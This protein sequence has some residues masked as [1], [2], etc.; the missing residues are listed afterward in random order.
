MIY[1][2]LTNPADKAVAHD[3]TPRLAL[4]LGG[5]GARAAYQ[6]G[7]LRAIANRYPALRIPL[8]TGVSAGAINISYL[9]NHTGSFRAQIDSLTELWQRLRLENVFAT[10]GASLLWRAIRIGIRLSLGLPPKMRGVHGMVDTQPLRVFLHDTLQPE[11]GC[12]PGIRENIERGRLEAVA[13]TAL[14]YGTGDT[15]TFHQGRPMPSWDQLRRRSVETP[16]TVEHVMA[17]AALPLFFPPVQIDDDWYGDGGIRLVN[18][19][20][21]AMHLGADR[22]LAISNHYGGASRRTSP[23]NE[24]PSPATV[25]SALYNAVFLDQLDQDVLEME[26]VNELVRE[27]PPEKRSGRREVRLLT[28]RPSEDIGAIA[29]ELRD[30]L[31]PTLRELMGRLGTREIRSQDFLA[32]VLFQTKFIERLIRLGARDGESYMPQLREFLEG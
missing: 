23:E 30:E 5:G 27:L 17:S 19:L 6:V 3:Q 1:S 18:P 25:L 13:L 7:V 26:M 32:T 29:H 15:V 28:I 20:A 31:P 12:L 4:T 11:N 14:S 16:L 10:S 9:A 2:T 8:L 21:P 22:I 24:A